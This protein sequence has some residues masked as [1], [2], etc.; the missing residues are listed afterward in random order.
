MKHLE[1]PTKAYYLNNNDVFFKTNAGNFLFSY[2]E[3]SLIKTDVKL[4]E[5]L[6]NSKT[7]V[8]YVD[9]GLLVEFL[10]PTVMISLD[11]DTIDAMLKEYKKNKK[12]IKEIDLEV[13]VLLVVIFILSLVFIFS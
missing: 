2:K 5:M 11:S 7:E 13:K 9:S 4:K 12:F 8:F 6:F 3:N 10:F 1:I